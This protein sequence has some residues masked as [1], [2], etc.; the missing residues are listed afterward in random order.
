[1]I[2][3]LKWAL[4]FKTFAFKRFFVFIHWFE[5]WKGSQRR[6]KRAGITFIILRKQSWTWQL[7]PNQYFIAVFAYSRRLFEDLCYILKQLEYF[8][9]INVYFVHGN[10]KSRNSNYNLFIYKVFGLAV[11]PFAS[12]KY[13]FWYK[14][15]RTLPLIYA[16]KTR[17]SHGEQIWKYFPFLL[18]L[19]NLPKSMVAR[20]TVQTKKQQVKLF[21]WNSPYEPTKATEQTLN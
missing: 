1:M 3:I 11:A 20:R 6:E 17:Y 5:S 18:S 4:I 2:E 7:W 14:K 15:L 8:S 21:T 19:T 16:R 12:L 10:G 9:G 13:Q